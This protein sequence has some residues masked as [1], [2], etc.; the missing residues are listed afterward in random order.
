MFGYLISGIVIGYISDKF[1]RKFALT[2]S[3]I[4][5]IISQLGI[6][7]TRNLYL[8]IG[9]RIIDGIGGYGRYIVSLI[10]CK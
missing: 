2:C 7:L 3:V 9:F 8:F 1:G 5:E 6:I 4:L 10:L